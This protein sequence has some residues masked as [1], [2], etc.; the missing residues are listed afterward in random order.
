MLVT[1]DRE[2]GPVAQI[3]TV[4]ERPR[5][6]EWVQFAVLLDLGP[7]GGVDAVLL[8]LHLPLLPFGLQ[9]AIRQGDDDRV[10][11]VVAMVTP[12]LLAPGVFFLC[13]RSLF[14]GVVC[15]LEEAPFAANVAGP[16]TVGGENLSLAASFWKPLSLVERIRQ[17]RHNLPR[18][19]ASVGEVAVREALNVLRRF[20]EVGN[21]SV[22][23]TP[24]KVTPPEFVL[25]CLVHVLWLD[26]I[27]LRVHLLDTVDLRV[28][29]LAPEI[30][31]RATAH[32]AVALD[33]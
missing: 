3:L 21:L 8:G 13:A 23:V 12:V 24:V 18:G 14:S 4:L 10:Q 5:Q 7:I 22:I 31:G 11:R 15:V 27:D 16:P 28:E 25:R 1:E 30:A 26:A 20:L 32:I 6:W 2:H 33:V 29:R 9:G 19:V 17:I